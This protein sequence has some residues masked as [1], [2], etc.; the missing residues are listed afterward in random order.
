[1]TGP[2]SPELPPSAAESAVIKVL[3]LEVL[4]C[5]TCKLDSLFARVVDTGTGKAYHF[6]SRCG[7]YFDIPVPS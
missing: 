2:D 1:M 7:E 6:C 3:Q 5:S 4:A